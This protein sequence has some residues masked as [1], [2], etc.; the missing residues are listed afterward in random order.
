MQPGMPLY[1]AKVTVLGEQIAHHVKEEEG[2]LFLKVRE[3]R[4]DLKALGARMAERKS[5]LM[6]LLTDA[7]LS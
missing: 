3:T 2:E 5:E 7:A 6:T 4:L 1:D